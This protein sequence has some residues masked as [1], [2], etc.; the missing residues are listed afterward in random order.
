[1]LVDGHATVLGPTFV[2]ADE[3]ATDTTGTP[4]VAAVSRV[5]GDTLTA[6]AV[7][8]LAGAGAY[9]CELTP[10]DHTADLDII[11]LTWTGAVGGK[12]RTYRQTVEVVGD[13]YVSIAALR[14]ISSLASASTR[15]VDQL[16]R[17]RNEIEAII[18]Q[19]R[20]TA[21]VH[22]VEIEE[23]RAD[24]VGYVVVSRRHPVRLL[25]LSVDGEVRDV[26]D[27]EFVDNGVSVRPIDSRFTPGVKVRVAYVH[28]YEAPP[29]PLVEAVREYVRAKVTIDSSSANRN[30]SSVTDLATGQVY[31]FGTADPRFGRWTGLEEVDARINQVPDER[32]MIA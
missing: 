17:F 25:A 22:R 6:P 15:P 20:G 24:R 7:T 28:G 26:E 5:S 4:T 11:D 1:M 12:T 31:R 3:T 10:A 9:S 21:Y 27:Y 29:Q 2:D 14:A 23:V 30:P 19:A 18:E 16:R 13:F 32:A 8:T